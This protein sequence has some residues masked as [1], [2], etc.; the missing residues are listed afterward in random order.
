MFFIG[1]TFVLM[2]IAINLNTLMGMRHGL[3]GETQYLRLLLLGFIISLSM[4]V[5]AA[6][7]GRW[8]AFIS[9]SSILWALTLTASPTAQTQLQRRLMKRDLL[10]PKMLTF[11]LSPLAFIFI[12]IY[13]VT[14]KLPECCVSSNLIWFPYALVF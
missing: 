1:N 5:I 14:L 4:F 11:M 10:S 9:N 2:Y 6:D 7:W 3:K 8:I 12:L 13:A